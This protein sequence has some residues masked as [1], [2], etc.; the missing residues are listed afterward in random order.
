[1]ITDA[2][3]QFCNLLQSLR[4]DHTL[5]T[6]L[7]LIYYFTII[8]GSGLPSSTFHEFPEWSN[9]R[10]VM[11]C[12]SGSAVQ[13]DSRSPVWLLTCRIMTFSRLIILFIPLFFGKYEIT[14]VS[15]RFKTGWCFGTQWMPQKHTQPHHFTAC[16]SLEK[17]KGS[18]RQT[19]IS[20]CPSQS[21][22]SKA[23]RSKTSSLG[24]PN[25]F[26]SFLTSSNQ[27]FLGRLKSLEVTRLMNGTK[28]SNQFCVKR[29]QQI[30]TESF[31]SLIL[32]YLPTILHDCH[33]LM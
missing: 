12:L 29:L 18:S 14:N 21:S 11:L 26:I 7:A 2:Y 24:R 3:L 19:W 9:S 25:P 4:Q 6:I 22:Y 1:M 16:S 33:S 31:S 28:I 5:L 15:G 30:C 20:T 13:D 32:R 23:W 17:S 10:A 8:F 27:V